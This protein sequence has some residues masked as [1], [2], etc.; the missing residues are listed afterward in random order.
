MVY[1]K[2]TLWDTKKITDLWLRMHEETD[3]HPAIIKE[4]NDAESFFLN[5]V[6]R[7]KLPEWIIIV[8]EL[9]DNI[10]GFIMGVVHLPAYSSCHLICTCEALYVKPEHRHTGIYKELIERGIAE[11]K[12]Q[13]AHQY[14]FIGSYE[15]H[16]MDFWAKHGYEPV[17]IVYR[18]K[19]A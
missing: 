4:Y 7:T 13:N 17:Q 18:Q 2:A 12:A 6:T 15:P 8:A 9:D 3:K 5:I 16:M 14:E 10:V 19:E 1:R 11:A